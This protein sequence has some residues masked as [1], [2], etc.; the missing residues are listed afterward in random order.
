MIEAPRSHVHYDP[1][2]YAGAPVPHRVGRFA[3]QCHALVPAVA[4]DDGSSIDTWENEGGSYLMTG[5]L[6]LE[7]RAPIASVS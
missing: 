2:S 4:C 5:V 7:R 3:R 1:R 6:D